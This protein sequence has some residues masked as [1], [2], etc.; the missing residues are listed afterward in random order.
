MEQPASSTSSIGGLRLLSKKKTIPRAK[1]CLEKFVLRTQSGWSIPFKQGHLSLVCEYFD[2]IKELH[3]VNF[4]IDD[5]KPI[6]IDGVQIQKLIIE[7]CIYTNSFKKSRKPQP[8][9]IFNNVTTLELKSIMHDNGLSLIDLVRLNN[10]SLN[11]L[12]MDTS[13]SMFYTNTPSG[14]TEFNFTRFNPFFNLLCSGYGKLTTLTL[15]NFGLFDY[16]IHDVVH[17][18]SDSWVEPPTNNF[19]TFMKYVS[20]I[21]RLVIVL[22]KTPSMVKTCIKCGFTEQQSDKNIDSLTPGEWKV[23]L[24]PLELNSDNSL[25]IFNYRNKLLYSSSKY[26]I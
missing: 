7:S 25:K 9:S 16:F 15:T 20:Q 26:N 19:E 24:K 11:H 12:I 5:M 2:V 21:N 23:F 13:S 10:T 14:N 8:N 17:E 18:D 22:R 6:N 3:L 4:I 1:R